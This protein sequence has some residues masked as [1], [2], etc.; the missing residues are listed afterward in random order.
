[1]LRLGQRQF[2]FCPVALNDHAITLALLYPPLFTA[3]EFRFP[4]AISEGTFCHAMELDDL[5][6]RVIDGVSLLGLG[7]I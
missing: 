7:P 3:Q 2:F 6:R 1:M 5:T 4:L